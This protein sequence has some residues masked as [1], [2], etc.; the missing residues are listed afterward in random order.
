MFGADDI[1]ACRWGDLV[2][3]RQKIELAAEEAEE[4]S[5]RARATTVSVRDRRRADNADSRSRWPS[6]QRNSIATFCP[7]T[8]PISLRPWRNAAANG[9]NGPGDMLPRKPIT[10]IA[11][12]CARRARAA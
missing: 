3:A 9:A 7:S 4:L 6:A 1:L 8:Y 5:R 2:M 10:G 12:C 11:L